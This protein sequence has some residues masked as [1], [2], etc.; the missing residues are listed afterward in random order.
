[1]Y[2]LL[3]ISSCTSKH[4]LLYHIMIITTKITNELCARAQSTS[5]FEP[6][7]ASGPG[8]SFSFSTRLRA[9]PGPA[10]TLKIVH[11]QPRVQVV[12]LSLEDMHARYL[13]QK[14]GDLTLQRRRTTTTI[15]HGESD[16]SDRAMH[17]KR[18]LDGWTDRTR[19]SFI[20][21]KEDSPISIMSSRC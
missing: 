10:L 5:N 9:N 7:V 1:M 12:V 17:A 16:R 8:R 2:I 21:P 15:G 19:R 3:L 14:D 20:F 11:T 4:L 18:A 6:F 13:L